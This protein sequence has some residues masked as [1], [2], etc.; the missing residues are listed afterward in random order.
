M[1]NTFFASD[2]DTTSPEMTG[3]INK[4][5]CHNSMR[6]QQVLIIIRIERHERFISLY[7]VTDFLH[8]TNRRNDILSIDKSRHL[9]L[10]KSI[11]FDC[12]RAPDSLHAV[13]LTK[14]DSVRLLQ[15]D[16]ES[17]QLCGDFGNEIDCFSTYG[18]WWCVHW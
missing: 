15:T 1:R 18:K 9:L 8:F 3:I 17:L 7:C 12:K 13:D 11:T 5:Q 4:P 16:S 6:F 10:R 14:P 2:T